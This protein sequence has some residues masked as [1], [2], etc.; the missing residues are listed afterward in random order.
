LCMQVLWCR[1]VTTNNPG[2]PHPLNRTDRKPDRQ[3]MS[4]PATI[5]IVYPSNRNGCEQGAVRQRFRSMDAVDLLPRLASPFPLWTMLL[6]FA[7]MNKSTSLWKLEL[8]T[9]PPT[10]LARNHLFLFIAIARRRHQGPTPGFPLRA[11]ICGLPPK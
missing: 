1:Q 10:L 9:S 3:T 6:A 5:E 7:T 4:I 8:S 11:P 2:R